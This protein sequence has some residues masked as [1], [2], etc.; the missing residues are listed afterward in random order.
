[1]AGVSSNTILPQSLAGSPP[2]KSSKE[3][4]GEAGFRTSGFRDLGRFRV[5]AVGSSTRFWV[6]GFGLESTDN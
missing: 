2:T 3:V 6:E 4:D 1:M 5:E